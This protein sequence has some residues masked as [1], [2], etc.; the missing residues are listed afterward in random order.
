MKKLVDDYSKGILQYKSIDNTMY[1]ITPCGNV[2]RKLQNENIKFRKTCLR[3][4][5]CSLKLKTNG[6]LLWYTIHRLVAIYYLDNSEDK[7]EVNHKDGNKLNNNSSN[8]EWCTVSE[9]VKHA[10]KIGLITPSLHRK[11]FS[12]ELHAKSIQ[13]LQYNLDG[14]FVKEWESI[15]L[16]CSEGF[17]STH[18]SGCCKGKLRK[19]KGYVWKYKQN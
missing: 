3:K 4:G 17:S 12:G 14:S 13:V 8:L 5:Y 2:F 18:I 9:N 7:P 1:Y 6:K 15:N 16:A 10:Y 11:G 19:H